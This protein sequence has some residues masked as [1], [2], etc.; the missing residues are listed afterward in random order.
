M[1]Y[2]ESTF[3][4]YVQSVERY[5][6]HPELIDTFSQFPKSV[7][8][9]ENL[10]L[11]GASGVGKY[12]QMLALLKKYSQSGLKYDKRITVATDKQEY[13]YRISDIHY[14]VDMALLGCN[15]K[16]LWHELF[17]QIID[18]VSVKTE[19]IGIIVCKNF[20]QIHTELLDIF[21]SYM[22]QYNHSQTNII[23]KFVILTEQVSF[24][25]TSIIN[26]CHLINMRRP[27]KEAYNM[28]TPLKIDNR[29]EPNFIQRI[30]KNSITPDAKTRIT[31]QISDIGT[32]NI[33]NM[34]EINQFD[35]FQLY[36]HTR[37]IPE[38][39]FD[40][41]CNQIISDICTIENSKFIELREGLYNILTYNLDVT[42][43]IWYIITHFINTGDLTGKPLSDTLE[44]MYT[45]LK[46]YNN[47]YRPIY[48]L[49]SI[50]FYII[51]K[52]YKLDE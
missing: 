35:L 38:D 12:S 19:K 2:Y 29:E 40:I 6:I 8:Q 22:Q 45:F 36:Q 37:P 46:Y 15:S 51:T 7:Y 4:E 17:F 33:L 41:V 5:N 16:T 43:C 21:Y 34:K 20:H 3:D 25:P 23:I 39:I 1:K 42:E 47:N 31:K 27:T 13:M 52:I 11:Y 26:N 18:I 30:S 24:I 14:E 49:E 10:I 32:E 50:V 9:L 28:I 44:R 48:H